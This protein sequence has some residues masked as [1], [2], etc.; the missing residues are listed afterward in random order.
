MDHP[1][2]QYKTPVV[3]NGPLIGF[4]WEYDTSSLNNGAMKYDLRPIQ[5]NCAI[6]QY[7]AFKMESEDL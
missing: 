3:L 6:H 5:H 4:E 2:K 1:A 7:A